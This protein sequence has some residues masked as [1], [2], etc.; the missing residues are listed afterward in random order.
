MVDDQITAE[1]VEF[2]GRIAVTVKTNITSGEETHIEIV[3]GNIIEN[4]EPVFKMQHLISNRIC[5]NYGIGTLSAVC[6]F[7]GTDG[8]TCS[9]NAAV[10]DKELFFAFQHQVIEK[11]VKAVIIHLFSCVP[12]GGG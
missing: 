7:K 8:G 11:F 6:Q 12:A 5:E 3:D 10:G 2:S 9:V 1:I 4:I